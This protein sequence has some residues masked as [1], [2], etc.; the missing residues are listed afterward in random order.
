MIDINSNSQASSTLELTPLLD[1]IFIVVVFLLLTANSQLLTLPVAIPSTDSKIESSLANN[2]ILN[3][4]LIS[5]PPSWGLD[6][7]QYQQWPAF[8][9]ALLLKLDST[10]QQIII[11]AQRDG[12]VQNL[13]KILALLNQNNIQNVHI[14]MEQE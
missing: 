3:I 1:I 11:A 13:L 7:Q 4:S 9:Q 5:H 12:Q 2:Q 6:K 14:L 8:K 10:Q